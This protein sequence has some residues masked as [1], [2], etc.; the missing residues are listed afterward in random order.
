MGQ[1]AMIIGF[2]ETAVK[3]ENGATLFV[4]SELSVEMT[5]IGLGNIEPIKN[6]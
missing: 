6:L 4:P 5:A 2:A 3:N 1:N